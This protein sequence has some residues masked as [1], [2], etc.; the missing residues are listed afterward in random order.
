MLS[1]IPLTSSRRRPGPTVRFRGL[2]VCGG[3]GFYGLP[4]FITKP[5][6]MRLDGGPGL[7]RDDEVLDSSR[8]GCE[9]MP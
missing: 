5:G 3:D 1:Q 2:H 6:W 4:F 8:R 7:R 9:A